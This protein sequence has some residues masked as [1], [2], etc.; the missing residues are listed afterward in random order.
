MTPGERKF[1]ARQAQYVQGKHLVGTRIAVCLCCNLYG[2][3]HV[4]CRRGTLVGVFNV[5]CPLFGTPY[6]AIVSYP[7]IVLQDLVSAE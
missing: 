5:L 7:L 2:D 1:C 4:R 3:T 6:G